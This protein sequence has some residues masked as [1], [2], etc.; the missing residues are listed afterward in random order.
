MAGRPACRPGNELVNTR[1]QM[2]HINLA[3]SPDFTA[4]QIMQMQHVLTGD[5]F[6][7]RLV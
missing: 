4:K 7:E 5:L 3:K 2:H 1:A 6:V